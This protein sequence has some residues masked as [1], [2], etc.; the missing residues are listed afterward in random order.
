MQ[1]ELFCTS[2]YLLVEALHRL[3]IMH[4]G[5]ISTPVESK[6]DPPLRLP[7]KCVHY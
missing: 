3:A 1:F 7:V 5:D 2:L 4:R 6:I